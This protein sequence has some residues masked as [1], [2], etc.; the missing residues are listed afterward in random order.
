MTLM[1]FNP[2]RGFGGRGGFFPFVCNSVL[3][4]PL[5]LSFVRPSCPKTGITFT[6]IASNLVYFNTY[7][8]TKLGFFRC[9]SVSSWIIIKVSPTVGTQRWNSVLWT[10]PISLGSNHHGDRVSSLTVLRRGLLSQ[11]LHLSQGCLICI[12]LYLGVSS[13]SYMWWYSLSVD[14]VFIV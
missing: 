1:S 6:T 4:D 2:F 8:L 3:I 9:K 7:K 12:S 14:F 10:S 11:V 13:V 5:R